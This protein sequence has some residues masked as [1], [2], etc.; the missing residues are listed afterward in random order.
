MKIRSKKD[1]V[2]LQEKIKTE[3]G[4]DVS[5]YRN[6]EVAENFAE[7]IL[8][9]QYVVSWVIRPII[10]ILFI[11]FSGFKIFDLAHVEYV[12]YATIGFVLFLFFG[13]SFGLVLLIFKMKKD[14][15]GI[16]DYSLD[17]LKQSISDLSKVN[18]QINEENKKEVLSLLF[19]GVI[20]IVTIP[21]FCEVIARRIPLIGFIISSVIKRILIVISDRLEFSEDKIN[22]FVNNPDHPKNEVL[23]SY[24]NTINSVSDT[25]ESFVNFSFK[26]VQVPIFIICFLSLSV[27]L[28]F[29]YLIH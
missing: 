7:L 1:V 4:I 14:I 29:L 6:E 13:I 9:P 18:G 8:L 27:L 12:I 23:S 22:D 20:H 17:I 15:W 24:V 2:A 16:T 10:F 11:Y 3:L 26:I 19:K 5:E 28:L 21:L 25:L